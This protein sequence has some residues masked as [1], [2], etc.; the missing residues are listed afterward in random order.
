M[1][2]VFKIL[3]VLILSLTLSG[4]SLKLYYNQID[5]L[6]SWYKDDYF[7]LNEVQEKQFEIAL[8]K[9]L[10]WHRF[11]ALPKYAKFLETIK[12]DLDKPLTQEQLE[13]HQKSIDRFVDE[14]FIQIGDEFS[15]ILASLSSEQIDYLF[16]AL[17]ES[18]DEYLE[19]QV[20]LQADEIRLERLESI[21]DWME[22]G[23]GE[24]SKK[25]EVQA[26]NLV[27]SQTLVA[28]FRFDNRIKWQKELRKIL[29]SNLSREDKA[30]QIKKLIQER[31][32]NHSQ[33]FK[34]AR[35]S[36]TQK[37][38]LWLV[39]LQKELSTEQKTYLIN[40][41]DDYIETIKSLSNHKV[42]S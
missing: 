19:E 13:K 15:P 10:N 11:E 5:W 37:T 21:N 14:F 4:C 35:R 25:Q 41:V 17:K 8:S 40:Q 39:N 31:N 33:E 6:V 32:Y 9:V 18:N 20:N 42:E 23:L 22:R 24:I 2:L 16:D 3:P 29:E 36:N 7:Q 27:F 12:K 34:L 38:Y 28:Q 26:K 30:G 1:K